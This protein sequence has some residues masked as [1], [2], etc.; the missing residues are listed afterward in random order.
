MA[1][2]NVQYS[3]DMV[4]KLV[5]GWTSGDEFKELP[6]SIKQRVILSAHGALFS[7]NIVCSSHKLSLSEQYFLK[8]FSKTMSE[9]LAHIESTEIAINGKKNEVRP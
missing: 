4:A 8:Q 6:L 2:F 3:C 5:N 7:L 9:K 1:K